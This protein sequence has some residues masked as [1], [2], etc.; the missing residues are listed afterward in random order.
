MAKAAAAA[1]ADRVVTD[2]VEFTAGNEKS[3]IS[4]AGAKNGKI[5][6][7]PI[8]KLRVQPGFN[9]RP[10]DSPSYQAS[11][12]AIVKSILK[13][14][15]FSTKP[16]SGIVGKDGDEDVIFVTDGH[17]R[18][19]AAHI[20]I[21]QGA[22]ITS[23]PVILK[24]ADT[25]AVDLTVAM[26]KE[27]T[28]SPLGMAATAVIVKRLLKGNLTPDQIAERLGITPRYVSDLMVLIAS[29][30]VIRDM[31]K[32]ERITGTEAVVQIRK[33]SKAD[34]ADYTDDAGT[35]RKGK[36]G[37]AGGA[38]EAAI[39]KMVKKAEE[40]G[41]TKA[42]RQDDEDVGAAKA[43][44]RSAASE[45][46]DAPLPD[47]PR[48][49]KHKVQWAVAKGQEFDLKEIRHFKNL[50]GDTD[51]YSLL[52]DKQGHAVATEDLEFVCWF[53]RPKK[54]EDEPAPEPRKTKKQLAEEAA[55]AA[56]L[57]A[58]KA[59]DESEGDGLDDDGLEPSGFVADERQAELVDAAEGL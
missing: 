30:R 28:G 21:E 50:V 24:P 27:N 9:A 1:K 40:R 41:A 4:A 16:L 56:A 2:L 33:H 47:P 32:L 13:E 57:E 7:V 3:A 44:K 19:E 37:R 8:D 23:L 29:S 18:K 31:V 17:C 52:S 11:I 45:D 22:E 46:D 42:T 53:I 5:L 39:V 20:A 36:P 43:A 49:M 35:L 12:D 54:S 58:A 48:K 59:D 25:S 51:W 14:G 15:F 10:K 55:A 34:S 26:Y 6:L 38:A